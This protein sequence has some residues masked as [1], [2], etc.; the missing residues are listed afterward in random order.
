M[1]ERLR[2]DVAKKGHLY[3][4]CRIT[5]ND[6]KRGSAQ[7][8]GVLDFAIL[9]CTYK[10]P[11]Q[12]SHYSGGA[13]AASV[14]T[15]LVGQTI[16]TADAEWKNQNMSPGQMFGLRVILGYRGGGGGIWGHFLRE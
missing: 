3:H 8:L 5:P 4:G 12:T 9:I 6:L 11:S 13:I 7:L 16:S 14:T 1:V 2:Q 15:G 10:W